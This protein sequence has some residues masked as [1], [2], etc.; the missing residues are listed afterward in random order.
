[1][2]MS[3]RKSV[4]ELKIKSR[5]DEIERW[6]KAGATERQVAQALGIAYSTFNKYKADVPEFRDFLLHI[7]K[8]EIVLELR[9]ALLKKALGFKYEEA[10]KYKKIDDDGNE[11]TYVEVTEKVSL[12]DVAAI[13]LALKN[14]DK[15]NWSNDPASLDL[16]K[17]E[18]ELKKIQIAK[19]DW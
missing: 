5:F 3:G 17:Q 11:H 16:K 7:D 6:L 10:K 8:T 4:Y 18:L 15:D 14:Y 19:E 2:E 9:S 12:P 13:N 1:M